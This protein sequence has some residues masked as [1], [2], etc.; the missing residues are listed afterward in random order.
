VLNEVWELFVSFWS[1]DESRFEY[2]FNLLSFNGNNLI[3]MFFTLKLTEAFVLEK[4][5][6]SRKFLVPSQG[7]FFMNDVLL[8]FFL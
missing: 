7:F 3:S 5:R 2:F 8:R 6:M 1:N 4:K